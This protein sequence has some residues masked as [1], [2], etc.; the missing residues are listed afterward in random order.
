MRLVQ[1]TPNVSDFVPLAKAGRCSQSNSD[2][3]S[4]P[5]AARGQDGEELSLFF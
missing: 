4:L 3:A 5:W 1:G 2:T